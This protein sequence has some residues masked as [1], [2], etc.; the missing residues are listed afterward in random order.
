M[1]AFRK[2]GKATVGS[3]DC[4]DE[5]EAEVLGLGFVVPGS[6][7]ELD[8]RFRVELDGSQ[9]MAERA[10]WIT[11]SA[12]TATDAPESSSSSLRSAS[13]SQSASASGS[14]SCSR[15]EIS[16]SASRARSSGGSARAFAS[17]ASEGFAMPKSYQIA[18]PAE[19]ARPGP[20]ETAVPPNGSALSCERR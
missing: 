17:S 7:D 13:R 15:L 2:L 12:P 10:F 4:R 3:L 8:V 20:R 19:A 9:R 1:A 11:C 6:G 18:R 16:F 5:V 14:V